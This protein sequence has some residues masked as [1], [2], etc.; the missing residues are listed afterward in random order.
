MPYMQPNTDFGLLLLFFIFTF[1]ISIDK[2]AI[3]HGSQDL[4]YVHSYFKLVSATPR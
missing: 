2:S 1:R 4:V 3:A